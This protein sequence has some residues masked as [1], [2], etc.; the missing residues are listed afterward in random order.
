MLC[1]GVVRNISP[2]SIYNNT[3]VERNPALGAY[4]NENIT[5][6]DTFHEFGDTNT[7]IGTQ[8]MKIFL[9]KNR[10]E[11]IDIGM[12][13]DIRLFVNMFVDGLQLP[14]LL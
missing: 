10:F 8:L 11:R 4:L 2:L 13:R 9:G 5:G 14:F 12:K 6:M 7:R 1:L 3:S